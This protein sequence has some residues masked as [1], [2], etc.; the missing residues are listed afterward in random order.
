[1]GSA[2]FAHE[3]RKL[4]LALVPRS[5]YGLLIKYGLLRSLKVNKTS[6]NRRIKNTVHVN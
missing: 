4:A 6:T 3:S 1:M 2:K 5:R